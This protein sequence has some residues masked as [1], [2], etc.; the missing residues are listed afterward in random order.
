MRY[1][2]EVNDIK[3]GRKVRDRKG[4][5]FTLGYGY[6]DGAPVW[7]LIR[8]D[9][10]VGELPTDEVTAYNISDYLNQEQFTPVNIM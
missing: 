10:Y 8:K 3:T 5:A 4:K 2:W 1:T 9:G 7:F 6:L